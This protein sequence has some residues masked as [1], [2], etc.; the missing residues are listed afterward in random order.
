MLLTCC[1][2][3]SLGFSSTSQRRCGYQAASP[4][5]TSAAYRHSPRSTCH[6]P[7]ACRATRSSAPSCR[8]NRSGELSRPSS[9]PTVPS[10]RR[11]SW[12]RWSGCRVPSSRRREPRAAQVLRSH[13]RRPPRRREAAGHRD[14]V[15]PPV[16]LAAEWERP[17]ARMH[18]AARSRELAGSCCDRTATTPPE[19]TMVCPP[20]STCAAPPFQLVEPVIQLVDLGESVIW[21]DRHRDEVVRSCRDQY[22]PRTVANRLDTF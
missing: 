1:P 22:S 15:A 21:I 6:C 19:T 13:R 18:R 5:S 10:A 20:W 11:R 17:A 3:S 12:L 7:A 14:V 16:P 2:V 4:S 9:R 8:R